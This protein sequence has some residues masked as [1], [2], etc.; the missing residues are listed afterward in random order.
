VAEDLLQRTAELRIVATT[1][2]AL[3]VEGERVWRIPSLAAESGEARE[4]FLAR[5]LAANSDFS[6]QHDD[7]K[8][9]DEICA[10]LDGIPLAIE[11]AAARVAHLSLAD[12][13]ARLD[14]R[15]S[16]LSGGRRARRQRQQTLQARMDWSWELLDPDEQQ[17]LPELAVFRGGFDAR[18]VDEV[19][20]PPAEGTR[21]EVLSSL[22]DRSNG[23]LP[24]TTRFL[25]PRSRPGGL[26]P[27]PAN[28]TST[29][30]DGSAGSSSKNRPFPTRYAW[31]STSPLAR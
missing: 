23:S 31:P 7:G 14:E 18:G 3:A 17:M 30:S 16:L 4:L 6:L 9:V 12:L 15:F 29:A 13:N 19:C 2:E 24:R 26:L 27:S 28:T 5:A 21:F 10:R 22:V 11:L 25:S 20:S 1:R 8:L